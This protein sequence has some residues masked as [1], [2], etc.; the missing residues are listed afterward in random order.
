MASCSTSSCFIL[1]FSQS[2]LLLFSS[3]TTDTISANRPLSGNQNITSK[4]GN[5]RLGFFVPPGSPSLSYYV[6]IW[7]NK[8]PLLTPVW[9]ANRASPVT[10][11]AMSELRI[12]GD[13]NLALLVNHS[14]AGVIWSTN[15][16]TSNSRVVAVILD[17]GNLQLRDESN[18]SLVFWQSFDHPTD[19][20]L[21]GGK[22]GF[23]KLTG[24]SQ[25]LT[26]WKSKVDP[27][28]GIF[29][30]EIDPT[31]AT[32]EYF[33]FWNLSKMYWRSGIWDGNIFNLV[34]E[35]TINYIYDFKF[36]NV[37]EEMYFNYTV[38]SSN[39]TSRFVLD[40]ESGQIQQ[41][42]WMEN[43]QSWML[44]WSQP[45]T[46]CSVYGVC[47]PFGS[48]NDIATPFYNCLKGFRIKSQA[49]WELGD[50]SEGC[51]RKTP[52]Q[53]SGLN[54]NSANS[55]KDGFFEMPNVKLPD[56][57]NTL[58]TAGSREGCEL[59]CLSDCS[60]NAYSYNGSGCFV[61]HGGLL[62]LQEQYN[63]SDAGTLY[64]RLAAS[65]LQSSERN[66]KRVVSL[67]IIC[68]IVV[69]I[70]FSSVPAILIVMKK[71][72]SRRMIEK[73]KAMQGGLVSFTY[74]ELRQ[75]T[76]TFSTKL[77]GGGFGSVFKG[78]LPGSNDIAV[79]KLEGLRQGEKQFR[80]EVSTVGRI[81]HVNLVRLLGFCSQGSKRLL[82]YE[83]MPN[84]SLDSHLFHN[85]PSS[86]LGWKTRYQI[87]IGIAR[88]IAY[89]HEQCRECIIHCDIKPE[90]ILLDASFNPKVADFG[91]AKLMGRDFSRVL[92]TL[93]GTKGYL[94][95]EW[96]SGVAITAKADVYSYGMVLLEI[97]SGRRNL[98]QTAAEEDGTRYFPT[99]AASKL[100]EG[101]AAGVL[102]SKLGP[103]E[104][105]MEELD[106]A[107]KIACWCIQ[108]DESCRP[109]MGQVV[110]VLEG[111]ID[112]HDPPVPRSLLLASDVP[113]PINFFFECSS[114]RS[115]Q[116]GNTTSNCSGTKSHTSSSS[117]N[118]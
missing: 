96:I 14:N 118:K 74:N 111:I 46:K 10:D 91:L 69:A 104:V 70:L 41:S 61:W 73:A 5:F 84:G 28:P 60:C 97:I 108:D 16:T 59:A 112:V 19:T 88:G 45:K 43:T 35:M 110:Q 37:S 71:R 81:Q 113:Q 49:D 82:V 63:Q 18:A 51:E 27:S 6:G 13:G 24:R 109:T 21:P 76:R 77:G 83:F 102:D 48:C 11:P 95:P 67:V 1:F 79:K 44:F 55:G 39:I 12:S 62:N 29:T 52:L 72:E 114:N 17:T 34:P 115:T 105:N 50:K 2:L 100:I 64:L 57:S 23:N 38:K 92:T 99:F 26:S 106:R 116:A 22:I 98:E 66:K 75:A 78:S 85:A 90:N 87:A 36:V 103:E 56:N 68:V 47:G 3:A 9:V 25:H 20:W 101:D 89:L 7:Y 53:C 94:A 33:I 107:C 31:G 42:T 32:S 117:D 65:E 93:R 58:A 30:L 4:D 54:N 80:T 86:R 15:A 40:S 8:I